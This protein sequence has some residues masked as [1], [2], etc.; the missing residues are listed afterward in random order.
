MEKYVQIYEL[1]EATDD[2]TVCVCYPD[3][4]KNRSGKKNAECMKIAEKMQ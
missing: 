4:S 1:S 3:P 2:E